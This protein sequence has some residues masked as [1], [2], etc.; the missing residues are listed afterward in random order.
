[1]V[2]AGGVLLDVEVYEIPGNGKVTG[3]VVIG[4]LG[5]DE[6]V[7]SA[8]VEGEKALAHAY[9]ESSDLHAA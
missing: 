3:W 1:M 5:S 9:L 6:N 4:G 8:G 7:G 2:T